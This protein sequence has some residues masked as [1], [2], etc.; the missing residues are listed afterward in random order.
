MSRSTPPPD[1]NH[2]DHQAVQAQL[3]EYHDGALAPER[4]ADV[5]A[6]LA[7]CPA[8]REA[9]AEMADAA[10]VL[11]GLDKKSPPPDFGEQLEDK[12]RRRSAGRFFGRKAFGDRVPF[13]VLAVVAMALAFAVYLLWRSTGT[14][15]LAPSTTAKPGTRP[16]RGRVQEVIPK[17]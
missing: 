16:P 15:T 7:A 9:Y 13:E 11:A 3:T 4:A 10:R 17:P 5:E 14:G 1:D 12:I 6:H 2:A 8:C